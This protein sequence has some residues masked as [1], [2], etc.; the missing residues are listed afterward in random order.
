MWQFFLLK[1]K[2]NILG[3]IFYELLSVIPAEDWTKRILYIREGVYLHDNELLEHEK[4]LLEALLAPYAAYRPYDV[5]D[6]IDAVESLADNHN[7]EKLMKNKS[8][9]RGIITHDEG[10]MIQEIT[11]LLFLG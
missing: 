2:L 9:G 8:L 11:Y 6:V 5:Q 10:I 3:I 7:G 1:H 4:S